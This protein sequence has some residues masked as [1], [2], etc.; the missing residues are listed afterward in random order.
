MKTLRIIQYDYEQDG[1]NFTGDSIQFGSPFKLT[2]YLNDTINKGNPLD[3]VWFLAMAKRMMN[4]E[5][6]ETNFRREINGVM[7]HFRI[8]FEVV[9]EDSNIDL[10]LDVNEW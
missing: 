5:R 10:M 6:F 9:N 7:N 3:K 1:L 2:D 4:E 8:I